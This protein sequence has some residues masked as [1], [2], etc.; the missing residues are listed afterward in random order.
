MRAPFSAM[1]NSCVVDLFKEKEAL[2]LSD[3][4][5]KYHAPEV[6]VMSGVDIPSVDKVPSGN[7][8]QSIMKAWLADDELQDEM[9]D[10]SSTSISVNPPGISASVAGNVEGTPR[11]IVVRV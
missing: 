2:E 4:E 3:W 1:S 10:N 8:L 6:L 9:S 5:V 11:I 7:R